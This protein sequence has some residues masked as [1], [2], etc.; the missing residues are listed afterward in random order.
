M[1]LSSNEKEMV[2]SLALLELIGQKIITDREAIIYMVMRRQ[3]FPDKD[4]SRNR[5]KHSAAFF[6]RL[7]NVNR[8]KIVYKLKSLEEKGLV[9]PIYRVKVGKKIKEFYNITKARGCGIKNFL[10]THYI[11]YDLPN[12]KENI[13]IYIKNRDKKKEL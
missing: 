10:N 11:I 7:M 2:A 1:K 8:N 3:G 9:R 5:C 4:G 13:K 6:S 12:E